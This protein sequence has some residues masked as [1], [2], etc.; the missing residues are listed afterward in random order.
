MGTKLVYVGPYAEGVE[1][2]GSGPGEDNPY[3]PVYVPRGEPVE[4]DS[5]LAERL[6]EQSACWVRPT[7][8]A[9]K[10]AK[11]RRASTFEV[12]DQPDTT[13]PAISPAVGEEHSPDLAATDEETP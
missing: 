12:P 2:E 11:P 1:L 8:K 5:D 3:P 13:D 9:A 10:D 7:T 4:I 6:L